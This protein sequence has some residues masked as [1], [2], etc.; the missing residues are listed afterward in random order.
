MRYFTIGLLVIVVLLFAGSVK[1]ET[2]HYPEE[3]DHLKCEVLNERTGYCESSCAGCESCH[4]GECKDSCEHSWCLS[5]NVE[6]DQC[7]TTCADCEQ[8]DDYGHCEDTCNADYCVTCDVESGQCESTCTDPCEQCDG[9]GECAQRC[10][11]DNC[12]ICYG[13]SCATTCPPCSHCDGY[14]NCVEECTGSCE[15]CNEEADECQSTCTGPCQVCSESAG[16]CV[17]DTGLKNACGKCPEEYGFD[18]C[19]DLPENFGFQGCVALPCTPNLCKTIDK[20]ECR[21]RSVEQKV[22]E[23]ESDADCIDCDTCTID[24]CNLQTKNCEREVIIF[25]ETKRCGRCDLFEPVLGDH[26]DPSTRERCDDQNP[27]TDDS[28]EE[29]FCVHRLSHA[30]FH[31]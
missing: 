9:K 7:E 26:Y 4:Y 12:E 25:D 20:Q 24:T 22:Y 10:D 3:C 6:T 17:V 11:S 15:E 1:A 2:D 8:C 21:I 16:E 5:C 31:H 29:G 18:E 23:C 19:C 27:N 28:C 14:G 13:G 30:Y